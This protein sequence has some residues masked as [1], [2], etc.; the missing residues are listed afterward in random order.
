[1]SGSAMRTVEPV[2]RRR[3][4]AL[5]HDEARSPVAGRSDRDTDWR[6]S[7][8]DFGVCVLPMPV[9]NMRGEFWNVLL[10]RA[11]P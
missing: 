6:K 4:S 9:L 7:D 3:R 11:G 5:P 8:I 2:S 1:M 10:H